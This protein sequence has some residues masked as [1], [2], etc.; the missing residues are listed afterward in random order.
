MEKNK[1]FS[2]FAARPSLAKMKKERN[3]HSYRDVFTRD[4][5]RILYSKAFRRLSGKTQVF[6]NGY[7]DNVRTRLTHTLEVS[8]IAS[9][10]AY[11]LG[12]NTILVEAISLGHDLGHA[13][14]GHA[15][16]RAL[17]YVMN[18]CVDLYNYG[19]VLNKKEKGFKHNLQGVRI[20]CQ[21]EKGYEN[22][23]GLNLSNYT[24]WGIMNHSS[25][26]YATCQFKN[27]NGIK[28]RCKYKN[29][30]VKCKGLE[31]GFYDNA[32]SKDGI[33]LDDRNNWTIEGVIVGVADE[34]AQR[35]HDVEDG[36]YAGLIDSGELYNLLKREKIIENEDDRIAE[37]IEKRETDQIVKKIS[38]YVI[39]FYVNKYSDFLENILEHEYQLQ[40][41]HINKDIDDNQF[42]VIMNNIYDRLTSQKK[43]LTIMEALGFDKSLKSVDSVL[44][45]HIKYRVHMSQLTQSMDGKADYII[46]KLMKAYLTN[47]QQ[48][49]NNTIISIV[50]ECARKNLC[51]EFENR[52]NEVVRNGEAR[53]KLSDLLKEND[54]QFKSI[55]IRR[56]CDYIA[57]MTDL[58]AIEQFNKLYGTLSTIKC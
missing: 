34:I 30:N 51:N 3:E 58:Y 45:K 6:I 21:L 26:E 50:E 47:P 24:V 52:D 37:F 18:G 46:R 11:R 57:G 31:V 14:F 16:E 38:E 12:L 54:R 36:I 9:T 25:K 42:I 2:I 27:T 5:D 17:N 56:I 7:G 1:K 22:D 19:R 23:C 20:V 43:R 48:L 10:I 44:H 39:E 4:R 32:F 35:H 49:P 15:G 28:A 13:P 29:T 41:L 8:Q 55:L 40:G 33:N 53:T